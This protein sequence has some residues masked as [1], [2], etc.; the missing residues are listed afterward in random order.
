MVS[1]KLILAVI[2]V[3]VVLGVLFLSF[4]IFNLGSYLNFGSGSSNDVAKKAVEYLN[5]SVLQEGQKATLLTV[6]EESGLVKFTV[7]IG[8]RTYTSY[9]SKDG[10]LLFHEGVV[11][12]TKLT[13]PPVEN[14]QTPPAQ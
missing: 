3:L 7:D 6:S 12:G 2:V 11:I 4:K 8:G 13:R 5:A 9:A 10:K 14:Q 1:K